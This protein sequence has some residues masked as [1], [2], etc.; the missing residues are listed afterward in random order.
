MFIQFY[1]QDKNWYKT[2]FAKVYLT[3]VLF[4][5]TCM[6]FKVKTLGLFI[7]TLFLS[8]TVLNGCQEKG[9]Q[10][11]NGSKLQA[12]PSEDE[13]TFAS[14][15]SKSGK[16]VTGIMLNSNTILVARGYPEEVEPI[17]QASFS[18][19]PIAPIEAKH[20]HIIFYST[21][22]RGHSK[23]NLANQNLVQTYIT[24]KPILGVKDIAISTIDVSKPSEYQDKEFF[25][26]D[27]TKRF[28]VK[29]DGGCAAN[30]YIVG[31]PAASQMKVGGAILDSKDALL[32][33]V[34]SVGNVKTNLGG[35]LYGWVLGL[36]W[37]T[38]LTYIN[39]AKSG[40]PT[41]AETNFIYQFNVLKNT[42]NYYAVLHKL[43]KIKLNGVEITAQNW[44]ADNNQFFLETSRCRV[45]FNN[46]SQIAFEDFSRSDFSVEAVFFANIN[47]PKLSKNELETIASVTKCLRQSF[48]WL[49][50]ENKEVIRSFAESLDL[51]AKEQASRL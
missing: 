22:P 15:S 4:K 14:L 24:E 46:H 44:G 25:Y 49:P 28:Q 29:I 31:M 51:Y 48:G 47:K 9:K 43:E 5:E 17:L 45:H 20:D 42:A 18:S 37:G 40:F 30:F 23:M 3:V 7:P 8:F 13:L 39:Q 19:L 26:Q 21:P 11:S 12:N 10:I 35:T 32:G 36:N 33:I 38:S 16:K 6:Y 2:C 50:D 27:E 1:E 34:T 41:P